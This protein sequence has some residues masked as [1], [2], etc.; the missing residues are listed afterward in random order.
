MTELPTLVLPIVVSALFVFIVSSILHTVVPFHKADYLKLPNE[1]RILE[2]L[3]QFAIPP[4]DY[5]APRAE[6]MAEMKTPEFDEKRKQGP[7][8]V[9][10]IMP[11]GPVSMGRHFVL[12]VAYSLVVAFIAAY[13][14][15]RA[16]APGADYLQVF[17][18]A[19]TTTFCCYTLA[20]WQLSIWYSRSWGTTIRYTI[21]GLIYALLTAGVF[22]W[23]WPR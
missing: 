13:V 7:V 1:D 6:S 20:L 22:G 9:M 18:F 4:G 21:D 5:M 17:R 11:S 16:L 12:W 14:T 23:L 19:G 15:G 3:R 2:A 8:L 10:T